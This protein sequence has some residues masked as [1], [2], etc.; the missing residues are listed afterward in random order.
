MAAGAAMRPP[1]M[2][3]TPRWWSGFRG[4]KTWPWRFRRWPVRRRPV[5]GTGY[6]CERRHQTESRTRAQAIR[7]Q[8]TG[9]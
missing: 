1:H 3:N 5:R 6:R 2:A 4:W 8:A 9:L 7:C